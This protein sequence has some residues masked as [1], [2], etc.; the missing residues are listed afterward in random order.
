[1]TTPLADSVAPHEPNSVAP[2]EAGT[3]WYARNLGLEP[4]LAEGVWVTTA[5]GRQFLDCLAAAGTMTLGHNHPDVTEA[6]IAFL[7]SGQPLQTLDFP[8]PIRRAFVDE[9]LATLP[10]PFQTDGRVLLCSPSG[11]DAIEAAI[12]CCKTFTGRWVVLAFTGGY[13]GMGHA[14]LAL[15]GWVEPKARLGGLVPYVYHLPF[16]DG[17]RDPFGLGLGAKRSAETSANYIDWLLRDSD[18]G[19]PPAAAMLVEVVQGEGGQRPAPHW[20]LRRIRELTEQHGIPLIVDE[21]QTGMGRTGDL[22]AFQQ[23]GI[24]PDVIVT[25]KG[26]GGGLPLAVVVYRGE[27]DRWGPGAHGG[28]FEGN[29]LAMATGTAALRYTIKEQLPAHAAVMGERLMARLSRLQAAHPMIGEVRGRG[30]M[31]GID[32][33]DPAH[34]RDHDGR[35]STAEDLARRLQ[36]A[37]LDEGLIVDVGGQDCTVIRLLPPL[38]ITEEQVDLIVDRVAAALERVKA[39]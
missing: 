22:W 21:V 32:I 7:K 3:V 1:M 15:N 30:L 26:I 11:N 37:C 27:L 4:V 19:I 36:I 35:A 13:H 39:G 28:T 24:V 2:H 29:Q 23:A 38:I 6:A 18:S 16:P 25:A 20:W 17:F 10:E 5:D 34:P 8:T 12:K 33:V 9:L 31:V 14:T